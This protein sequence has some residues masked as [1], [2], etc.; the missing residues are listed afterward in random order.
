MYNSKMEK[1]GLLKQEI[2]F[3]AKEFLNET[4]NSQI[5]IVSHFDTDGITSASILIKT[6]QELD[7]TFNVKIIKNLEN[8]FIKK[9]PKNKTIIFLDLASNSLKQIQENQTK[10]TF[11]L[12]HHEIIQEIPKNILIANPEIY[13][14]EKLSS[15]QIT[16]LFCEELFNLSQKRNENI[17]Q[18]AKLATLGK[19]GDML[20][21]EENKISKE[22]SEKGEIKI[23]KGLSIYPSTRPINRTL[24]YSSKPYIKG[25]T[26]EISGVIEL[27]RDSQINPL[28]GKYPSII[29]LTQEQVQNLF[30]QIILRE[31]KIKENELISNIYL[32]K[33]FNKLE[34][35]R[36]LSAKI[37]ACSR[38][39]F[40]T[41]AILFCL[42]IE[43]SKKQAQAIYVKYKQSII[44]A[45]KF[46]KQA[47]K[48]EEKEYT[49]INAQDNIKDSIIG[50]I[51]SIISN[52]SE[53]PPGKII[54]AMAKKKNK[55][56]VSAR[57]CGRQGRNLRELLYA[58]TTQLEETEIGGHEQAAGCL[59]QLENQEKFIHTL[60]KHL[61][62][63]TIKIS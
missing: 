42:E 31:P 30:T 60:K 1:K 7:K 39:G 52:S 41:I 40:P 16:F 48:I 47:E 44:S 29:E 56:K 18:L 46:V 12:D 26:G 4:K 14:E 15:S 8:E 25:V 13:K 63:E 58:V 35:A 11:I 34:D 53:H 38:M 62:I 27:L 49:I 24:E 6:L 22:I 33:H 20:E 9:L 61:K 10:K 17:K 57:N 28:N 43:N 21:K 51:T 50:T 2:K 55:I 3:L 32:I 45:L 36:E 37:N 19:I 23:K 5:L 54:I 59:I